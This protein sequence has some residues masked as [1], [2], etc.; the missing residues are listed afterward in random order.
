MNVVN[1]FF[2]LH[3]NLSPLPNAKLTNFTEGHTGCRTTESLYLM[4]ISTQYVCVF[5]VRQVLITHS[6]IA[7]TLTT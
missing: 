4:Q 3:F 7:V 2:F 6:N 1:G 5:I